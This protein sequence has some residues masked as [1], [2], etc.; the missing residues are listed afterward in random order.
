MSPSRSRSSYERGAEGGFR[1]CTLYAALEWVPRLLP[2]GD[3]ARVAANVPESG[4]LETAVGA[5]ARRAVDV[6][7]VDDDVVAGVEA[8]DGVVEVERR[9][10]PLGLVGEARQ[11]HHEPEVVATLQL[12]V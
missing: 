5:D 8:G 1:G 11:R 3:A 4:P 7:A 9:R 10:D 2:V 6:C 12:S